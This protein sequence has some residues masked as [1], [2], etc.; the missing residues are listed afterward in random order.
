MDRD[1]VARLPTIGIPELSPPPRFL[2]IAAPAKL[3][4]CQL[5]FPATRK[6]RPSLA[7]ALAL[8]NAA[9]AGATWVLRNTRVAREVV[10]I[11]DA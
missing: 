1:T 6:M 7:I 4:A 5:N 3:R 2:E 11:A 10:I 8:V 9:N